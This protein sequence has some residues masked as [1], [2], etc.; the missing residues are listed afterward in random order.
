MSEHVRAERN[1]EVLAIT[2]ARPERRN[3]ITVAM[4]AALADAIESAAEDPSIRVITIRGVF[5]KFRGEE[6]RLSGGNPLCAG[7]CAPNTFGPDLH[8]PGAVGRLPGAPYDSTRISICRSIPRVDSGHPASDHHDASGVGTPQTSD[9]HCEVTESSIH[10][11]RLND[12]RNS[13]RCHE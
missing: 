10:A 8:R 6:R 9:S 1:G 3:A 2:L 4:Y 13:A 12:A 11:N 7:L 5:R